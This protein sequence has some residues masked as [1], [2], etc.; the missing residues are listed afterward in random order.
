MSSA[1]ISCV[2]TCLVLW[3]ASPV[4]ADL[5][6]QQQAPVSPSPPRSADP[7]D[8]EIKDAKGTAVLK[9]RIVAGDSGKPLRRARVTIRATELGSE[10]QRTTSTSLD[11]RY[12]FRDLPAA[13]YRVSVARSGYLSLDH[14]Q[15][16]PGEIGRP[17]QLADGQT[18]D[19]VDF[20]MPRMGIIT[21]RVTDES[22]DPI[23]G[24]GVFAARLMFFEGQRRLVPIS[25]GRIQTDDEGEYRISRLAP[26]TYYVMA[27]TKEMWTVT[28]NGQTRQLGYMP[29]YFPGV[30]N[31]PEA[32]RLT[33]GAGERLDA[34]DFSLVPGRS[35]KVSGIAV[36]SAQRPFARVSMSEEVRGLGFASFG[37]GPSA[38]VA[39]DGTFT[40]VNVPPGEYTISASRMPGDAAGPA[41]VAIATLFVDGNDIENLS[42]VGS[43]GGTVR[44]RIIVEGDTPPKMSA[45]NV[46]V[47][48]P[49]RNQPSPVVLGLQRNR[50]TGVK[51]DGTF[52]AEN[53]FGKTR[54]QV[55]LPEAWMLKSIVHD[56][57]DITD[58]LVEL[59]SGQELNDVQVV[60][61]SR[62]TTFEGR[63]A[64]DKNQPVRDATVLVFDADQEKWFESTR[65]VR[66]TRPDQDGQWRLRGMPAGEYLAIA[67]DYVEDGAW[68]DPE[69]LEALRRDASAVT[70]AEGATA[71][72]ALK[73]VAP[74]R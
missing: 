60:I 50:A 54:F 41:E 67:L 56:G 59:G 33:I 20:A 11:G 47:R 28:E 19:K 14:G 27:T 5:L 18:L 49:L 7:R 4:R 13:R 42:L 1:A 51:E 22:G 39:G 46:A 69:Y 48:Q 9:G 65:R 21:G 24:V 8:G 70:L 73:V 38:A 53:V 3:S 29:T 45:V 26:G 30:A 16:R 43:S 36:D 25:A 31:S 72:V 74:K 57:K 68:N 52:S 35:A 6:D 2:V 34:I 55:T 23:E 32:R 12:E 58:T 37:A 15:R 63:L 66:A 10:G 17:V 61:T 62:V 64:D 40:I 44:G 71:A